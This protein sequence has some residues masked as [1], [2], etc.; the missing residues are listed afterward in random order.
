MAGLGLSLISA[1]TIASEVADRRL[2]V[3]KVQGLPIV[4]VRSPVAG[5]HGARH[6]CARFHSVIKVALRFR[7]SCRDG[8]GRRAE[9]PRFVRAGKA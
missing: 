9:V 7:G 2:V 6:W 1:H 8:L 4:A 5:S 3:L